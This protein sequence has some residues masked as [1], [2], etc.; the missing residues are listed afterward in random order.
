MVV[1]LIQAHG[2]PP[3]SYECNRQGD[4]EENFHSGHH[5]NPPRDRLANKCSASAAKSQMPVPRAV[6]HDRSGALA[7][8]VAIPTAGAI[9]PAAMQAVEARS[10][11]FASSLVRSLWMRLMLQ[12]YRNLGRCR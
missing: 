10:S 8:W 5:F 4:I 9:R 11:A 6:L 12:R 7:E 1:A 2:D 3:G